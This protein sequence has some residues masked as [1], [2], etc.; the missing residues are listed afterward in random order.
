MST[1]EDEL[2]EATFYFAVG[3]LFLAPSITNWLQVKMTYCKLTDEQ[4]KKEEIIKAY[5]DVEEVGEAIKKIKNV[6]D[7]LFQ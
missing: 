4:R 7:F 1:K 6:T 2:K 3:M 5:K